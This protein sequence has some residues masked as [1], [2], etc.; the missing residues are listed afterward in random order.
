MADGRPVLRCWRALA[1]PARRGQV[2]GFI[3][4]FIEVRWSLF[5]VRLVPKYA[6]LVSPWP[7]GCSAVVCGFGDVHHHDA[8]DT[9]GDI[10]DDTEGGVIMMMMMNYSCEPPPC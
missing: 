9:P 8:G 3:Y 5:K 1:N 7:F 4:I 2:C 6:P 10:R